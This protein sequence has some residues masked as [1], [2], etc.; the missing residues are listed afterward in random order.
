MTELIGVGQVGAV[1]VL[2]MD[3]GPRHVLDHP[4]RA[5]LVAALQ[6]AFADPQTDAVVISGTS[7]IFSAGVDVAT[8]DAAPAIA[9]LCAVIEAAKKPVVVALCG[10]ASGGG[11]E[12]ALAAHKRVADGT[13]RLS[14]REV[15]LGLLPAGATQRLPRL[16]GGEVALRLLLS[17]DVIDAAEALRVGLVDIV[18]QTGLIDAAVHAALH[19]PRPPRPSLAQVAGMANPA[20]YQAAVAA[21]RQV[22]GPLPAGGRII[23]CVEAALILP[24]EQGLV[25]AEQALRDLAAS[26]EAAGLIHAGMAETRA[27]AVPAAFA[28]RPAGDVVS[29]GFWGAGG[30]VPLL[31]G[32]A[33][34][35]G[36]RVMIVDADR[37]RLVAC[38]E[39]VAAGQE[40]AVQAGVLTPDA[41]EEAWA[42]LTP[43][44]DVAQLG[45]MGALILDAPLDVVPDLAPHAP[46]MSL[47]GVIG[48]A[49]MGLAIT[50]AVAEL[51]PPPGAEP[52]AVATALGLLRDLRLRPMLAGPHLP[53]VAVQ[54][55]ATRLARA[56]AAAMRVMIASGVAR[57]RVEAALAGFGLPI[58]PVPDL[59]EPVPPRDM[60]QDEM[61]ARWLGAVANEG[62]RLLSTG[63]AL[64][65]SDIDYL[66]VAALGFPRHHGGPMYQAD[67]RGLLVLRRDLRIWAQDSQIWTPQPLFDVLIAGGRRLESVTGT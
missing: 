40:R 55:M 14:A 58:P 56:G 63:R 28:R 15:T 46:V 27:L 42:R 34:T 36:L 38:L 13:A 12:L 25:F 49:T 6:D 53:H 67:R 22:D 20:A 4:L 9:D 44:V 57:D 7:G 31:A 43:G 24:P 33:A 17:G 3:H 50:N 30:A 39:A 29:L 10:A 59:P 32:A 23:D 41:R 65:A 60:G 61:T 51:A 5:A 26:P 45:G 64:R 35:A 21:A 48:G 47:G 66:A 54:G 2:V 8:P 52:A 19:H 16:V 11:L 62:A 1:R 37:P 18:V